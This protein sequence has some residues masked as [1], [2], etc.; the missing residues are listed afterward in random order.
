M[1]SRAHRSPAQR[2]FIL[3][4][5]HNY[6]RQY[7]IH[8]LKYTTSRLLYYDFTK[9]SFL[10]YLYK[11]AQYLTG[12][13]VGNVA[14]SLIRFFFCKRKKQLNC[15]Q[16]NNCMNPHYVYYIGILY[17][18]FEIISIFTNTY[19]NFVKKVCFLDISSQMPQ[20]V[21]S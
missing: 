9:K 5:C 1:L 3:S 2:A 20:M 15:L 8:G 19:F 4:Q 16:S 17:M 18:Q 11:R 12:L 7:I 21:K 10:V 14:P 6:N 13:R